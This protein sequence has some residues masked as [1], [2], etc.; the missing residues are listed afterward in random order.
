MSLPSSNPFT[1]ASS[2]QSPQRAITSDSLPEKT[3]DEE[4]CELLDSLF[5]RGGGAIW[6]GPVILKFK[7]T[8]LKYLKAL[9]I[10]LGNLR[11]AATSYYHVRIISSSY[12]INS[13]SH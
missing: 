1:T 13:Y 5:P 7:V 10:P 3:V 4:C 8:H 9:L 11:I 12:V 2:Q 6:K